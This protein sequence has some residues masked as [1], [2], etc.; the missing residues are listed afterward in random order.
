MKKHAPTCSFTTPRERTDCYDDLIPG[1]ALWGGVPWDDRESLR[2]VVARASFQPGLEECGE[3]EREEKQSSSS[4]HGH[5]R[6]TTARASP[7]MGAPGSTATITEPESSHA[8]WPSWGDPGSSA[9]P[10]GRTTWRLIR[11]QLDET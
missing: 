6:A 11:R 4:A 8:A 5:P 3:D 10:K 9:A 7:D 2:G 1:R